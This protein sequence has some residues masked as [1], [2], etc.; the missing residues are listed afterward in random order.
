MQRTY[1]NAFSRFQDDSE[2]IQRAIDLCM[3][4]RENGMDKNKSDRQKWEESALFPG[5]NN[6]D[7]FVRS[8][9]CDMSDADLLLL[10]QAIEDIGTHSGRKGAGTFCLGQVN[11]PNPITVSLRMGHS[12]G[13]L[14]DKYI[15]TSEVY[16]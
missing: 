1:L 6:K 14:R 15:F 5:Q 12:I 2:T 9:L 7:R 4:I 16:F 3:E 11:G 8:V 13:Q 10:G